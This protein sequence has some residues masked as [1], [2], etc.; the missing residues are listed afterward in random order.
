[1]LYTP[2]SILFLG[3]EPQPLTWLVL[4]DGVSRYFRVRTLPESQRFDA[5]KI[6]FVPV[7]ED[8]CGLCGRGRF[9][10][11]PASTLTGLV[12]LLL[13]CFLER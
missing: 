6:C 8:F 1:M 9:L 7:R 3:P 11:A 13:G 10:F 2:G 12:L 5:S 4:G